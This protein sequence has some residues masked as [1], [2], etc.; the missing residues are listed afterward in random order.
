MLNKNHVISVTAP[1][2]FSYK[3]FL[4]NSLLEN[5]GKMIENMYYENAYIIIDEIVY[6]NFNEAINK[7]FSNKI[8]C[9]NFI[10]I[11]SGEKN[12]SH[13]M[14]LNLINQLVERNVARK[15]VLLAIGGGVIT[16]LVGYVA[17]SYLRGVEYINI[18]TTLIGQAD[19]SVGGK[20]AINHK[21]AKNFIGSFWHPSAVFI[22]PIFLKTLSNR[23]IKN[24]LAEIIKVAIISSPKLLVFLKTNKIKILDKNIEYLSYIVNEAIQIKVDLLSSDPYEQ[25]LKRVLNLGHTIGHPIETIYEYSTIKHGEAISIGMAIATYIARDRNLCLPKRYED[26]FQVL[27]LSMPSEFPKISADELLKHFEK[28]KLV[29]NK[30]LHFVIPNNSSVEF[31]DVLEKIELEKAIEFVTNYYSKDLR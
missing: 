14:F 7:S 13:A 31:L 10:I 19:A 25:D 2:D 1:R 30:D 22:D 4:Q 8:F 24:G 27:S 26:I 15:S 28:I 3:I 23:E 17:S 16:D 12:K 29:R 21:S 20:V 11:P 18:P 5:F 6:K 9:K